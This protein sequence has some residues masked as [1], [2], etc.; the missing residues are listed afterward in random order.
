MLAY[1]K[2]LVR[3]DG[4]ADTVLAVV[5]LDPHHTGETTVTFDLAALGLP[6]D[7]SLKVRDELTGE[8]HTWGRHTYVR[9]EPRVAPAHLL[10]PLGPREAS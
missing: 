7:G 9:L 1:S 6:E 8:I 4:S 5:N 3:P 2:Q 10:V